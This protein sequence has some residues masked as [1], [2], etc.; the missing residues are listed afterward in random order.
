MEITKIPSAML[1]HPRA[2]CKKDLHTMTDIISKVC[3]LCGNE[4]PIE[5]F[6]TVQKHDGTEYYW[7][8]CR[9]CY[10]PIR[11]SRE[12]I[13][14]TKEA[15]ALGGFPEERELINLLNQR[16]IFVTNGRGSSFTHVDIVAWGCVPIELKTAT[17]NANGIYTFKFTPK[18]CKLGIDDGLIALRFGGENAYYVFRSDHPMFYENGNLRRSISFRGCPPTRSGVSQFE[19]NESRNAWHLIETKRLEVIDHLITKH[20]TV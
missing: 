9:G 16:G 15:M 18:Q 12:A 1:P 20:F 8:R 11:K 2:V 13:R 7:D 6:V 19:I 4:K 10:D 17:I 14:N 3:V 5:L